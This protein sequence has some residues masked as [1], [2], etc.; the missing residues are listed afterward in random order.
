MA[1]TA[2]L[3]QYQ[4]EQH[5][6][7][8]AQLRHAGTALS[9]G[10]QSLARALVDT[11]E[12]QG[13]QALHDGL[14]DAVGR[15]RQQMDGSLAH[16]RDVLATLA[17]GTERASAVQTSLVWKSLV[18]LLIGSVLAVAGTWSYARAQLGQIER[19]RVEARYLEAFNRADVVLCGDGL[20]ANIDPSA[21]AHGADGRYRPIRAR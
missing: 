16:T 1:Q 13:R 19:Q 8:L 20:C 18:A 7:S 21:K 17:K 2:V 9:E 11:I 4:Q 10:S 6:A 14:G 12:A 15:F 5:Q 3:L